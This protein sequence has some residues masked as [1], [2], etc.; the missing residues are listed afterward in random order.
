MRIRIGRFRGFEQLTL[1]DRNISLILVHKIAF[2]IDLQ[3]EVWQNNI[4]VSIG[5]NMA[6]QMIPIY[7]YVLFELRFLS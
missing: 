4:Y 1:F 2:K 3:K 6:N 5:E 7:K